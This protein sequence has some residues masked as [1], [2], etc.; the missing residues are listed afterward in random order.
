MKCIHIRFNKKFLWAIPV[1]LVILASF[2]IASYW[3]STRD[4][5]KRSIA[6][7][8]YKSYYRITTNKKDTLYFDNLNEDTVM[9]V[10]SS[11]C[12]HLGA[13]RYTT[14]CWINKYAII[15][16][17]FG[18]LLMVANDGN[19]DSVKRVTESN[20]NAILYKEKD[21]ISK[22]LKD[23]KDESD[24]LSYYIRVHGVQDEG[25]DNIS[26]FATKTEEKIKNAQKTIALLNSIKTSDHISIESLTDYQ[27]IYR[28]DNNKL[29]TEHCHQIVANGKSGFRMIQT[30]SRKTPEYA[31]P[32]HFHHLW[33]WLE[34][35]GRTI[36]IA[37][38]SGINDE[39]FDYKK[40]NS[41]ITAGILKEFLGNKAAH[42]VNYSFS[43]DGSPVFSKYGFFLGVSYHG[44]VIN[45]R[46]FYFLFKKLK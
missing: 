4:A 6:I 13:K 30:D 26:Q 24:D 14:G 40:T 3:P 2:T 38:Y 16:S 37:N 46:Q 36:F 41:D 17:C 8:E 33:A 15:P 21:K 39:S 18:K 25:Y 5:M 11:D 35:K 34:R 1:I 20:F 9:N 7:I 22:D 23:L 44:E 29:N 27:I 32:Q 12:K 45:T 19:T 43:Q 31:R 10:L 28:D 42:T